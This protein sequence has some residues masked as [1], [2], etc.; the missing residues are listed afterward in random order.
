MKQLVY[1]LSLIML[2]FFVSCEL[3]PQVQ[4]SPN[5]GAPQITFPA[6]GQEL[7][8]YTW[9]NE[10]DSIFF[11]WTGANYGFNIVPNYTVLI[12]KAGNNFA[13]PVKLGTSKTDTLAYSVSKLNAAIKRL[14]FTDTIP[15][16]VEIRVIS[17]ITTS[18]EDLV[19]PT[20]TFKFKTYSEPKP[21]DP[22]PIDPDTI[23]VDPVDPDTT[24]ITPV[25]VS[26][27]YLLGD[28]TEAGWDNKTNLAF[29]YTGKNGVF[30]TYAYLK[31]NLEYK[32]ITKQGSW[33]PM[34]GTDAEG[35]EVD[36]KL[37]YRE[38]ETVTDPPAIHSPAEAGYYK[39][40]VDTVELVYETTPFNVG[41]VGTATP[42][43]WDA[44][45]QK[46][47]YDNGDF[48]W[49]A[50]VDLVAGKMKFRINDDWKWNR[51]GS[52]DNLTQDGADID[53]AE[54]GNYTI[55]LDLFSKPQKCT[56]TKN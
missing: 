41:I 35:T 16:D 19:S 49:K 7:T 44:P 37:V 47:T 56:I 5:P 30:E 42:N 51:G 24:I 9:N 29:V 13:K 17:S 31:A 2:A 52:V 33:A 4:I 14:K 28:A 55:T 54:N 15:G 20:V 50:T 27:I 46:M 23:I 8:A 38:N 11:I 39:I 12:D 32:F 21:V 43:G 53:I 34:W 26:P 22:D 3:E 36:G 45:D 1:I 18:V 25:E 6:N 40:V 10:A 48:R